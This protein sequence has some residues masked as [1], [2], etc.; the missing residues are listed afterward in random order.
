MQWMEV[1]A[2]SVNLKNRG[3]YYMV[4]ID[5]HGRKEY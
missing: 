2:A 4:E 5:E 3:G 1:D